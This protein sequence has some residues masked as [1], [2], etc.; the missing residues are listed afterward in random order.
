L[1]GG[2]ARKL[3]NI[4]ELLVMSLDSPVEI[5]NDL[6]FENI[7]KNPVRYDKTGEQHYD[8]ISAFIKSIRGS[9]PNASLYYLARML[10]GGEDPK[11]IARR[12]IISASEDIGNANPNALILAN[13]TFSA[14]ANIG[15]PEAR[16]ILSQCVVYLA[17][18]AKSN[19]SYRA[20]NKALDLVDQT[21]DLSIPLALRNAPTKLM[22]E[23]NYGK[24][25]K[26]AHDFENNFTQ[27]EFLPQ[28]L[29]G[30]ILYEPGN[31]PRENQFKQSL[32]EKWK[33]K[34]N[35]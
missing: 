29:S 6:V 22:K 15:M 13:N 34:Y 18:S 8:I 19:A 25:Y 14:V 27:Q 26:Y 32:S 9:D 2:D 1:S 3:L 11:F 17:T 24:D 23:L 30:T 4:F 28:E 33:G 5:T 10:H 35:Y 21:G 12:L 31:N 16:I 7:T 20:I